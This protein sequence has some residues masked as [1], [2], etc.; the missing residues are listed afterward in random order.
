MQLWRLTATDLAALIRSG[1]VSAREAAR[2]ALDRLDAVNGRIN[3]VVEHR[4]EDVL[5][6]AEAV[7]AARARGEAAGPLA[8]VPVTIKVNAD[9]R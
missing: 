5:A 8:G 6:Q 2:D 9:Q 4:P 1:Q 7:D 3:A